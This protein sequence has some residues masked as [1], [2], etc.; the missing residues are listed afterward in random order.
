MIQFI[1]DNLFSLQLG[2]GCLCWGYLII[3]VYS[4]LKA[5]KNENKTD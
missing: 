2:I 3:N 4:R 5:V 1:E